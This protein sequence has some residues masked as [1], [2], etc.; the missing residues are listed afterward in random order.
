[1]SDFLQSGTEMV[2]GLAGMLGTLLLLA[3]AWG[4]VIGW[5][6]WWL[7]GV[8]W[9]RARAYLR[10]GAWVPVLLLVILAALVWSR[11]APRDLSLGFTRVPNFWWQ[12]GAVGLIAA[13]T[14]FLGHLQGLLG[15]HPTD[16]AV[17]PEG[18]HD[19]GHGGHDHGDHGHG[20][21]DHG[22]HGHDDHGGHAHAGHVEHH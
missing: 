9:L 22:N 2:N 1:M 11:L 20:G 10:E 6:A 7:K 17:Y 12:L 8:N 5:T 16:Y 4:L 21:Q 15:W 13:Y 3:M 18:E 14:L 19:H